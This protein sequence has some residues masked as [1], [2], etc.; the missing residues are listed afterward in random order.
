MDSQKYARQL[1]LR[2]GVYFRATDAREIVKHLATTEWSA[3][4]SDES[5]LGVEGAS[6]VFSFDSDAEPCYAMLFVDKLTLSTEMADSADSLSIDFA[7]VD[8]TTW[9]AR[10][11]PACGVLERIFASLQRQF[12]SS[13]I[14]LGWRAH[15]CVWSAPTGGAASGHARTDTRSCSIGD[16]E[17]NRTA[18][19]PRASAR[20][21][22]SLT[23]NTNTVKIVKK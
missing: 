5:S 3:I 18:P 21:S 15:V 20:R 12:P 11:T 22:Y 7:E 16:T 13:K 2:Y 19:R 9:R 6:I 8:L 23:G 10:Y 4:A 14:T 1:V 17:K